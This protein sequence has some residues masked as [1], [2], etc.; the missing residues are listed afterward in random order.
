MSAKDFPDCLIKNFLLAH[1]SVQNTIETQILQWITKLYNLFPFIRA[2][3]YGAYEIQQVANNHEKR[4]SM[5]ISDKKSLEWVLKLSKAHIIISYVFIFQQWSTLK[6]YVVRILHTLK[7]TVF[8]K[9]RSV[10]EWTN[11][12]FEI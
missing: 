10:I 9:T 1:I 6:M 3:N 5:V 2:V 4:I 11:I 7:R 8:V 12:V